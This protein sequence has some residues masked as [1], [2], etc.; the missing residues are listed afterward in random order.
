MHHQVLSEKSLDVTN[1]GQ[2]HNGVEWIGAVVERRIRNLQ[3][4]SSNLTT[5]SVH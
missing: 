3:V 1:A 4:V 5:V 2:L